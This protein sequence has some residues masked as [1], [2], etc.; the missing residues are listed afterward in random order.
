MSSEPQSW[1]PSVSKKQLRL[2]QLCRAGRV[3]YRPQG[4]SAEASGKPK[5][6]LVS[7]PR[8]ST[9]S[10]GCFNAIVDHLYCVNKA[11]F[12]MITPTTTAGA[13][14]GCWT[15]LT[16]DIIPQWIDGNFGLKWITKPRQDGATKKNYF[17][18]SNKYGT[19]SRC[20]LDT[21]ERERDV[22]ERFKGR[23]FSGMYVGELSYYLERKTFD[24]WIECLR[25]VSW[26][27]DD[28]IFMGDTNPAE[29]GQDSWIWKHWYD[30]RI[31][32]DV[33]PAAKLAQRQ[34]ALMEFTVHDNVFISKTRLSEQLSRYAHSEDLMARYARGEWKKAVGNSVF[35]EQFRPNIHI[36]GEYETATNV[37]P[38]II[39]PHDGCFEL[40]GGWDIGS[41][42]NSGFMIIEKY[43]RKAVDKDGKPTGGEESCFAVLDEV[44]FI[45]SDASMGE[46]V[47]E[48]LEKIEYWEEYMGKR[49]NWRHW[50]DRSAFNQKERIANI[51]HHA[52]VFNETKGKVILQA[53]AG[54][55]GHVGQGQ[56]PGSV[57]QRLDLTRKLL[58]QNRLFVCRSRCPNLIDSF[59]SL[60]PGKAG[61]VVEKNSKYK[62]AWDAGSYAWV[63]ECYEEIMYPHE[64]PQTGQG[65]PSMITVRM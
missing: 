38:E 4:R 20:Q 22:E 52:Y 65:V 39:V 9:K 62:H 36:L 37:S 57:R 18:I 26:H 6:V 14:G 58:F 19:V 50:S 41:G 47:A 43:F 63:S 15:V 59:Q 1:A 49:L 34:M 31:A 2:M 17:E 55:G 33:D 13:D 32:K 40:L 12:S 53:V 21:L 24:V 56:G 10:V 11:S 5:F 23:Q 42:P 25:G 8:F 29:E 16:K 60:R 48:C 51:A 61:A 35:F 30:F 28:L 44:V 7:G 3:D 27:E 54:P 64:Q 46:F 45:G